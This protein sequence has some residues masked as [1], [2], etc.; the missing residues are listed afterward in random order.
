MFDRFY[1]PAL[2]PKMDRL[3]T[4]AAGLAYCFVLSLIPFLLVTFTLGQEIL[5][6]VD[7]RIDLIQAYSELL[8]DILPGE[9]TPVPTAH[10]SGNGSSTSASLA[11]HHER[12]TSLSSRILRTLQ[13]SHGSAY[14]V[15]GFLFAVYTS[16]NLMTQI[17][18]TLL[19]IFD[20]HRRPLVWT[21]KIGIK[22]M[23]LFSI[24][25]LVLLLMAICSI[26][27]PV[28]ESVL[29]QI[30]L[31]PTHWTKP[32]EV[33]RNLIGIAALYGAFFLTYLLV[34]TKRYRYRQV[35]DGSFV[36]TSGW[37]LCSLV[38]AYV[39][40]KFWQTNAVYEALGSIVIILLWAQACAW[41]VILGACWMV[42]FPVR[43]R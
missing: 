16:F 38:F 39:L 12:T 34:P 26:V 14:F 25:M 9:A 21:L 5:D 13:H 41:S 30:H 10:S 37:V 42:R 24:W 22:T 7:S 6:R 1:G 31:D 15:V 28:F 4:Y 32:L 40:P 18:R 2:A 20:D 11:I 27:T 17:V 3:G 35:S 33:G 23:A 29:Q 8:A 43:R 36:A 19:F